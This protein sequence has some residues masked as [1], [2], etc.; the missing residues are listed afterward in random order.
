MLDDDR[1]KAVTTVRYLAHSETLKHRPCRS[2]G[3]NVT[4][5]TAGLFEADHCPRCPRWPRSPH[6]RCLGSVAQLESPRGAHEACALWRFSSAHGRLDA[7]GYRLSR[8]S[9][10][11]ESMI[12]M[13]RWNNI[14]TRSQG[15][16]RRAEGRSYVCRRREAMY[17]AEH[18][19]WAR[20]FTTKHRPARAG[21]I[22]RTGE[23]LEIQALT[24]PA[25][26]R[27]RRSGT[28]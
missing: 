19:P 12:S 17:P 22:P 8:P 14:G 23:S 5:P 13:Q 6:G 18:G 21:R 24:A 28:R 16:P 15:R 2:H 11:A 3:V 1:R 4:M 20:A 26:K 10:R 27:A 7:A 25:F 9:G